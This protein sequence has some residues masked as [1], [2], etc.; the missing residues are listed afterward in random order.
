MCPRR[1]DTLI[2]LRDVY[3]W[4]IERTA[5]VVVRLS[6]TT[7]TTETIEEAETGGG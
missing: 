3:N 7:P 6:S 1:A 4:I 5:S 2:G